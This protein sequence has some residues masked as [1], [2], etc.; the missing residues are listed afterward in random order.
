MKKLI[1]FFQKPY[2]GRLGRLQYF[3]GLLIGFISI[4]IGIAFTTAAKSAFAIS[5]GNI[6]IV[7]FDVLFLAISFLIFFF[8]VFITW[9]LSVRRWHDLGSSG[10]AFLL[11]AIPIIGELLVVI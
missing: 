6:T 9:S 5:E 10:W 11:N 8:S 3:I 4:V 1:F 7:I 2:V